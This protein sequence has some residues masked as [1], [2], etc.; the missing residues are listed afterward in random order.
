[1]K[2]YEEHL[3]MVLARARQV[4]GTERRLLARVFWYQVEALPH[5]QRY[6]LLQE[7]RARNWLVPEYL[8]YF[9]AYYELT[10]EYQAGRQ[11]LAA[12]L[13][14][15]R[16]RYQTLGDGRRKAAAGGER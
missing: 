1:M 14:C 12:R 13:D 9:E 7:C 10:P 4:V 6:E 8:R 15:L 16:D 5:W 2:W 11:Y 3:E